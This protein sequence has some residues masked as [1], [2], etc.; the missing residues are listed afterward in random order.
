MRTQ[1]IQNSPETRTPRLRRPLLGVAIVG[2][3]AAATAALA[4][5]GSG[6]W[7]MGAGMMGGGMMGGGFS[8]RPVAP[9]WGGRVVSYAEAE[10]FIQYGSAHGTADAKTNTVTFDGSEVTIN[11]VAVQ[12][13]SP[14]QTFELHGLVNPTLVIPRGAA[15]HL[16][17]INMDY[18]RT[19]EHTVEI[20]SAPPPY[21]DMAMM[22]MGAPV[23]QPLPEVPWRSQ[24]DVEAAQYGGLGVS[25]V[26]DR[27][28]TYWY[29]CPTPAHAEKGMYG[30]L[31]VR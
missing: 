1:K 13:G 18:G 25:F 9:H 11:L 31:V 15:V 10:A 21:P 16:N 6:G 3:L 17:L 12:P 14:D 23:V 5:Y 26:A 7:T 24:D 30:K 4:Q 20:V 22:Y 28:G 8:D 29:V 27:P 2:V 19:M